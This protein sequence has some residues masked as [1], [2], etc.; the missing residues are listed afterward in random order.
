MTKTRAMIGARTTAKT[1]AG[2][3]TLRNPTSARTTTHLLPLHALVSRSGMLRR[4]AASAPIPWCGRIPTRNV[5]GNHGPSPNAPSGRSHG[6]ER[7]RRATVGM[8]SN[9][10]LIVALELNTNDLVDDK[11]KFC[12]ND[13][14]TVT[15]CASD[16]DITSILVGL[17]DLD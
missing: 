3:A 5:T 14:S 12:E 8:V 2:A 9:Y 6:A 17:F 16:L 1:Q 15:W 13:G 11:N 7:E 4:S 10:L